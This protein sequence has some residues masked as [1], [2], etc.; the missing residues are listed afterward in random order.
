MKAT[1]TRPHHK[2]KGQT[3]SL[4][5]GPAILT[6]ATYLIKDAPDHKTWMFLVS[7]C[8]CLCPFYWSQALS[9]KWRCSWNSADR[10]CS[11]Y[12]LVVRQAGGQNMQQN[13][14][15]VFEDKRKIFKSILHIPTSW[16]FDISVIYPQGFHR[17]KVVELPP[18]SL[19]SSNICELLLYNWQ[20]VVLLI[21]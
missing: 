6:T 12:I 4:F 15:Y 19:Y 5:Y 1:D 14:L 13:V 3:V 8:N 18:Y 20:L 9:R 10:R 17:V 21:S 7:P 11:N 16:H 2:S